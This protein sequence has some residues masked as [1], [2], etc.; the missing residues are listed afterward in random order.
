MKNND[1]VELE[2]SLDTIISTYGLD[3]VK[4]AIKKRKTTKQTEYEDILDPE[5][6]KFTAFPIKYQEIWKS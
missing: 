4:N 3:I 6:M 1:N 5:K 2:Q